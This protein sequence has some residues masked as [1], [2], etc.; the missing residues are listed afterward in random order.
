MTTTRETANIGAVVFDM[1]GLMLDTE[2]IYKAAWQQASA[3]LGYDVTDAAYVHLVG[4]PA[5]DCEAV[6]LGWFGPAFPIERFRS[7]CHELWRARVTSAGIA[8]KPGLLELLSHLKRRDIPTAV[9]TSSDAD[10][11]ELSLRTVGLAAGFTAVIT[12]DTVARGKPAPDIYLEAARRLGVTPGRSLALED[13]EAGIVAASGAG[14]IP[15]L[16]PDGVAPSGTARRAAFRVLESLHEAR[17]RI[18]TLIAP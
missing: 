4:R 11:T 16:I 17:E 18:D 13:S 10:Y 5:G 9:A 14:M 2:P 3:E 15:L 1:D 7:R 12:G 6:V 8:A